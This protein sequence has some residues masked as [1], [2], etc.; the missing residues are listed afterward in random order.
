M[1]S[2]I[3]NIITIIIV[4]AMFGLFLRLYEDRKSKTGTKNVSAS[5][6]AQDILDDPLVVSRAYFTEPKLGPIGDFEG[7]QTPS[8]HLWVEGKPIRV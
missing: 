3:L 6:V 2:I 1:L 5:D 8:E 4:I 7:Q